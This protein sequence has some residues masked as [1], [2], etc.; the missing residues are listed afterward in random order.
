MGNGER[1]ALSGGTP[2]FTLIK[3]ATSEGQTL[4]VP[5]SGTAGSDRAA[6]CDGSARPARPDGTR[7][8][9]AA[10]RAGTGWPAR[11]ERRHRQPRAAG[12]DWKYRAAR[13][14]WQYRCARSAGANGEYRTT[15][16][17]RQHRTAGAGAGSAAITGLFVAIAPILILARAVG[18]L[19]FGSTAM[20]PHRAQQP[21]WRSGHPIAKSRHL[22]SWKMPG[23]CT[24]IFRRPARVGI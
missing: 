22:C 12:T 18:R 23:I 15:G 13:T 11:L 5:A 24:L 1:F 6:G 9:R 16:T 17:N 8:H 19:T 3:S 10:G 2:R 20:P 14:D 21:L 7:R 4:T